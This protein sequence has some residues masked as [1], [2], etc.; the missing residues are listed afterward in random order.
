LAVKRIKF[1]SDRMLYI[2]LRGCWCRYNIIVLNGYATR[3][4]EIVDM[5]DNFYEGIECVFI[6]FP[7]YH[8]KI[9]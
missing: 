7:K 8:K 6:K 4:D 9:L 1:V 5:K 2:I 3:G